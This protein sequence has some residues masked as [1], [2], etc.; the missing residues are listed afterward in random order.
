MRSLETSVSGFDHQEIVLRRRHPVLGALGTAV[1]A[2]TVIGL[3]GFVLSLLLGL[4]AG[5][6]GSVWTLPLIRLAYGLV[7]IGLGVG[8]PLLL[9]VAVLR[10]W[11]RSSLTVT[12]RLFEHRLE[13]VEGGQTHRL[14]LA[15]STT[16]L[17]RSGRGNV[18]DLTVRQP[19][20]PTLA[21]RELLL[22]RDERRDLSEVLNGAIQHA[23]QQS[24]E[25][26]LE[27]PRELQRLR[28]SS[29]TM[30]PGTVQQ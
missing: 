26:T 2:V 13:I 24:G 7:S 29:E 23:T 15:N 30:S 14:V 25:G 6:L 18:A 8:L 22:D 4:F 21:L 11:L 5:M 3:G 20:K 17:R 28:Q 12:L 9:V 27:I 10:L 1:F 16:S 19:G